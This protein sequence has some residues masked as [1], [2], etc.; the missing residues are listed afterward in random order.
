M[1]KTACEIRFHGELLTNKKMQHRTLAEIEK[2]DCPLCR[3]KVIALRSKRP[4][5]FGRR[6]GRCIIINLEES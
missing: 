6:G 3:E 2:I 5:P 1:F 4:D